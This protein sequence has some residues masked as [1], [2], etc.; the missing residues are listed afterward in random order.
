MKAIDL[1][2]ESLAEFLVNHLRQGDDLFALPDLRSRELP[3]D[4]LSGAAPPGATISSRGI[5]QVLIGSGMQV[6][7]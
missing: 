3:P 7:L 1:K 2:P 6:K 5:V 4:C